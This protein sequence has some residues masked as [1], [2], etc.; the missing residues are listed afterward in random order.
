MIDGSLAVSVKLALHVMV[1][2]HRRGPRVA[3][4]RGDGPVGRGT[5]YGAS[6]ETLSALPQLCPC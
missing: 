2:V 3:W 6:R 4:P 5:V 1:L